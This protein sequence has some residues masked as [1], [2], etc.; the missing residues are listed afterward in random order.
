[1]QVCRT[2]RIRGCGRIIGAVMDNGGT[3]LQGKFRTGTTTGIYGLSIGLD[4]EECSLQCFLRKKAQTTRDLP[5]KP[6]PSVVTSASTDLKVAH[7]AL[8]FFA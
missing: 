1:M 5:D 6:T 8:Q 2:G 7:V 3:T 4:T